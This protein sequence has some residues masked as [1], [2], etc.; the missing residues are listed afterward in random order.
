VSDM[1]ELVADPVDLMRMSWRA[2]LPRRW[3]WT[4]HL[5]GD[6]YE[7]GFTFTRRAAVRQAAASLATAVAERGKP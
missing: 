7:V 2:L 1:S 3:C 6:R 4:Q 5:G